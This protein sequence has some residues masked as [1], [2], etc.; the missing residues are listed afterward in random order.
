MRNQ[1]L[2]ILH[3]VYLTYRED[4]S[5]SRER[6]EDDNH[7]TI[8]VEKEAIMMESSTSFAPTQSS[9][10]T[11]PASIH[12][13]SNLHA[14]PANENMET[15]KPIS[16]ITTSSLA[17][18][19]SLTYKPR[20]VESDVLPLSKN[21]SIQPTRPPISS[22]PLQQSMQ[23]IIE[24]D[25][26]TINPAYPYWNQTSFYSTLGVYYHSLPFPQSEIKQQNLLLVGSRYSSL[27]SSLSEEDDWEDSSYVFSDDWYA[28]HFI[29]HSSRVNRFQKLIDEVHANY[30]SLYVLLPSISH[31]EIVANMTMLLKSRFPSISP[32]I[33]Y[34]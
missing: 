11:I 19:I 22:K 24:E 9:T 23:R 31:L 3:I 20:I 29:I 6:S 15:T 18:N 7:E 4:R 25:K 34:L 12:I 17:N 30:K 16:S 28:S 27:I 14:T 1:L 5:F 13:S 32:T 33:L 10:S 8:D 26:P 21:Q 2:C